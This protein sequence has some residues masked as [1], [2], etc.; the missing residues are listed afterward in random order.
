MFSVFEVDVGNQ[1]GLDCI[2]TQIANTWRP[3]LGKLLD[4]NDIFVGMQS[5]GNL[6]WDYF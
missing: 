5:M 6:L 4:K 3:T 1:L 2:T